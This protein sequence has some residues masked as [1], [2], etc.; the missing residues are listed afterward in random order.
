MILCNFLS[1]SYISDLCGL[2]LHALPNLAILDL[3]FNAFSHELGNLWQCLPLKNLQQLYLGN[4]SF[5]STRFEV[6]FDSFQKLVL[7]DVSSNQLGGKLVLNGYDNTS[8]P[9]VVFDSRENNFLCP[10]PSTSAGQYALFSPCIPDYGVILHYVMISGYVAVVCTCLGLFVYLAKWHQMPW[11]VSLLSWVAPLAWLFACL[12]LG[13]DLLLLWKMQG[14]VLS[15]EPH[16]ANV[17]ER[18]VFWSFMPVNDVLASCFNLTLYF[19]PLGPSAPLDPTIPNNVIQ[20]C[21][22]LFSCSLAPKST[23]LYSE[24]FQTLQNNEDL[25]NKEDPSLDNVA[26]SQLCHRF[27]LCHV[28]KVN[29][30]P[31]CV[32]MLDEFQWSSKTHYNFLIVVLLVLTYKLTL[33]VGK[34]GIIILSICRKHLWQPTW[35]LAFMRDSPCL[36]MFPLSAWYTSYNPWHDL[37]QYNLTATDYWRLFVIN[38]VLN[39]APVLGLTFWWIQQVSQ[40][41][42]QWSDYFSLF[43]GMLSILYIPLRVAIA[44]KQ[45][46]KSYEIDLLRELTQLDDMPSQENVDQSGY[47]SLLEDEAPR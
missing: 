5:H 37:M 22:L 43:S 13:S 40:I 1:S 29:G 24:F 20:Q 16:C 21:C 33:E 17:N 30:L 36:I 2:G 28:V 15:E 8:R 45:A 14:Y 47:H 38:G 23:Q 26:F 12:S 25:Q 3:R 9:A 31:I 18:S 10:M 32:D 35:T 42:L 7:L 46:R 19:N 34:F 11:F 6:D 27:P 4:N 39:K 44:V 41:G